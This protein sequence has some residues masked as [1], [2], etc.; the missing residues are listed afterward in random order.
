MNERQR[1]LAMPKQ[2]LAPP[3]GALL[4]ELPAPQVRTCLVWQAAAHYK[5][6]PLQRDTCMGNC[7]SLSRSCSDS[8][9]E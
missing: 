7:N 5:D 6:Q 1:A 2:V 9:F 4:L 8:L 3:E